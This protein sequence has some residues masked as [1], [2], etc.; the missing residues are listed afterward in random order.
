[1]YGTIV[2]TDRGPV[3]F[4]TY[5][6]PENSFLVTS[7]VIETPNLVIVVDTQLSVPYAAEVA[8]FA[9][10]LGKP[11]D[12]AI[13]SH[14][15]SD[16]YFGAATFAAPLHALGEVRAAIADHG[17]AETAAQHAMFGDFVPASARTPEHTITEGDAV[18]DGIPFVFQALAGGESPASLVIGLPEQGVLVAQDLVYSKVHLFLGQR[19]ISHWRSNLARFRD[20]SGYDVVLA[21][22]GVPGGVELFDED[23]A[24]LDVAE[25]LL[26]SSATGEQYK[27]AITHEY[28]DWGG[29]MLIDIANMHLFPPT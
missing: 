24:Y 28:P 6:A 18:V 7:Q 12:R 22:H 17:D 20:G 26:G 27:E 29:L 19:D 25:K 13:V 11:L 4:H 21:G 14:A 23:I 16:H 10:S 9:A 3:R 1:M 8:E 5:V 15:H 2:T